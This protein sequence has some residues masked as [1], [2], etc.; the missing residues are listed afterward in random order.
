M[1]G[2]IFGLLIVLSI[3]Q[4]VSGQQ[5]YLQ[6]GNYIDFGTEDTF[7][8]NEFI[9]QVA[10]DVSGESDRIYLVGRTAS[11][12]EPQLICDSLT[13]NGNEDAFLAKYNH[14]GEQLW[15]KFFSTHYVS[16]GVAIPAKERP[17]CMAI[18]NYNGHNYIFVGGEIRN[19]DT[20][21]K[22]IASCSV[23]DSCAAPLYQSPEGDDWEGY[24]AKYDTN[25]TLL[26]WIKF[27]GTDNIGSGD[28]VFALTIDPFTNDVYVTGRAKSSNMGS[29]ATI[30]WDSTL[31]SD[32]NS[33]DCY[34]AKFDNCL[35]ELKFFS[36]YGG[37][38]DDRGHDIRID[39][40]TGVSI[41]IIAGTTESFNLGIDPPNLNIGYNGNYLHCNANNVCI[42]AFLMKWSSVLEN[43]PDWFLYFGGSNTD[44]GRRLALDGSGNIYWTGWTQSIDLFKSNNA[45]DKFY[46]GNGNN[47]AYVIKIGLDGY[48][49]WSTFYGG[50]GIDVSNAISYYTDETTLTQYVIIMGLTNSKDLT[51][52]TCEQPPIMSELNGTGT[53]NNM[54]VFV[55]KLT[56]PQSSDVQELSFY[57]LYGGSDLESFDNTESFGPYID[58]GSS[59]EL[60]L[61]FATESGDIAEVTGIPAVYNSYTGASSGTTD[62]FLGL[63]SVSEQS[64]CSLAVGEALQIEP[65][66][67]ISALPNPFRDEVSLLINTKEKGES[68]LQ[69]FDYYGRAVLAK[70]MYLRAGTNMIT[71]K[72]NNLPSSLLLARV[73]INNQQSDLKLI[74]L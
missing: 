39:T 26:R 9:E 4:E 15:K 2:F 14:C 66:L 59:N 6:W 7:H 70:Q 12:S 69:I 42:D 50:E 21:S 73:R 29:N 53:G 25:G 17:Y 23:L 62:G 10:V 51:C 56:D 35:S 28:I 47:D 60:Y 32:G 71:L 34:I 48:I 5:Y 20:S 64:D 27:G 61:S 36:Y 24:I 46:G 43:G 52:A 67:S 30:K 38:K 49:Q 58:F 13:L 19:T 18:D 11:I 74:K 3:T 54:D 22:S 65:Q 40:S 57:T 33:G 55:A 45:Y 44:R 41:P 72:L 68:T 16:D 8:G 37:V 63:I 31:N 1:E